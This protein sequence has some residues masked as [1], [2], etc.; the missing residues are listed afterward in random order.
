MAKKSK[1]TDDGSITENRKAR[2]N[3]QI[4]D[5]YE[6]GIELTGT[7]VKSIRAHKI[8]I[9]QGFITIRDNQSWL[10]NVDIAEYKEGNQFNVDSLRRRRLLLHKREILKLAEADATKGTSIVPLKV[11]IKKQ[12]VK[13]LIGVGVGKTNVDKRQT[14]KDRD[15]QRELGRNNKLR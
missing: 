14:I 11:Y 7:E 6:A 13:I 9:N 8:N 12:F 15:M 10:H 5:T 1:K 3:Y 2:F 4:I